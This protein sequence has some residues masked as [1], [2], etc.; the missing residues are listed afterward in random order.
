MSQAM[1]SAI[2]G[3]STVLREKYGCLIAG[4]LV[5]SE[6][7]RTFSTFNPATGERLA[8]VPDCDECDVDRA[9]RAAHQ[10]FFE[11][12]KLTPTER[13]GFCRRFAEGLLARA[14]VYAMLDALDG[15][16]P[17]QAMRADVANAAKLLDYFAGLA[18][19]LKG[20]TIP[21]TAGVFSFTLREPYGVVGRII[22]FNHPIMFA[23]SRIAAA[24]VAG[25]TVVLKPPEQTPLSALEMAYDVNEVFPPG[26]V[27]IITGDG[28]GAGAPLV[29]HPLVRRIA[30]TGSVEV[31][32]EIMRNA[33]DG[34]KTVSLE[35]GGKN[36][37]IVFPDVDLDNAVNSAFNGMNFCWTQG[38]SCGSTSRLFL[39]RDIQDEFVERLVEKIKKVRI[40]LPTDEK[41]EMG[42]LVSQQQYDKVMSYIELGKKEGARLVVGGG[43]PP[44]P[45]LQ[46]GYFVLPTVFDQVDYRMRLAQEEIF[47]PVQ[48]VL[49][50]K[51]TDELIEMA[52]SVMYGL[53]ASIW[54]R[55][56]ATAYRVALQIEAGFIWIN[57]S[58]RHFTGVPFG[59]YKQSG[60]GREESLLELL[61][62][63][64]VKSVNVNVT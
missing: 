32:R 2:K 61:S 11:W 45:E 59:G 3:G 31:G 43:K 56:F 16:N 44:Q 1:E 22:P 41:T 51:S 39:H 64:Q 15:G 38:Q 63:T 14:D 30:F 35:L 36:P 49:T 37:L 20:E 26:V 5:S 52:N 8:E 60:L 12:R 28:S 54:T 9:V 25:N 53:T 58:S 7:G 40:G 47:G 29:R 33:A 48:S 4:E 34:L 62:Y 23:A 27:N 6:A 17:V 46:R 24:L 18:S 42:C 57:D 55:D 19:E 10:A 13:G 21:S 50:W